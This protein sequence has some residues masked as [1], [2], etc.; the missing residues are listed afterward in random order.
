MILGCNVVGLGIG[1]VIFAGLYIAACLAFIAILEWLEPSN[2]R[3]P[4]RE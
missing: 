3:I 1:I 2:E 4:P